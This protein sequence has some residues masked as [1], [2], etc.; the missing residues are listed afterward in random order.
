M[1]ANPDSNTQ[2][3]TLTTLAMFSYDALE[4]DT[5]AYVQEQTVEIRALL[6]RAVRDIITIGGKLTDVKSRLEHGQFGAWLEREFQMGTVSAWNFMRVYSR[7]GGKSSIIEDLPLGPTVMYLLASPSVSDEV[8]QDMLDRAS[9]GEAITVADV[10][11]A[12]N[13]ARPEPE[14]G[15]FDYGSSDPVLV[16]DYETGRPI[17]VNEDGE[18]VGHNPNVMP[19]PD[20]PAYDDEAEETVLTRPANWSSASNEWYTPAEYVN[21]AREL[22]GGID[23]DPASNPLAN[24]TIQAAMFYTQDDD[25]L[26]QEWR[27]RVWLNPPYGVTNGESNAGVWARKLADE[28]RAGNVTEAVLLVNANTERKWFSQLW[29]F[30][31]CFTDHRIQFYTPEGVGAQP[32]DGNALVYLGPN[33]HQFI[34][35]FS[36]FGDVAGSFT[37]GVARG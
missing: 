19:A 10:K 33:L 36:A 22:M 11:Q 3:N 12:I 32:V 6:R 29:A 8:V 9:A 35:V 13:E 25:G 18:I 16:D 17:W 15:L 27:G 2:P 14:P 37:R 26:A 23:L 24:E 4:P 5:R 30:P 20:A 7:F 1:A 31:I 34:A 28:Y 21:A